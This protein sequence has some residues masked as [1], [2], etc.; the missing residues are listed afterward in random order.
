MSKHLQESLKLALE[1]QGK[2]AIPKTQNPPSTPSKS[3]TIFTPSSKPLKEV[4]FNPQVTQLG[5]NA[6]IHG[7]RRYRTDMET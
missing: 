2:F 6:N 1:K 7:S 5:A 4:A 3:E